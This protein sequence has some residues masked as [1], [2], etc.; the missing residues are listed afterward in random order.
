[1]FR[2][3]DGDK[4]W[5]ALLALLFVLLIALLGIVLGA[6]N[7]ASINTIMTILQQP[8]ARTATELTAN[9]TQRVDGAHHWTGVQ[10]DRQLFFSPA[11]TWSP[12]QNDSLLCLQSGLFYVYASMQ[13]HVLPP[14]S[15]HTLPL[16]CG[17]CRLRG[18]LRA[19][20]Q[21]G[22]SGPQ[23]EVPP[24]LTQQSRDVSFMSKSFLL[25]AQV[26][27][28]LRVQFRSP[29]RY[30]ALYSGHSVNSSSYNAYPTSATLVVS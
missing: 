15:N 29:C 6:Q 25:Q 20:L 28:V 5:R 10:Y 19:T 21:L 26:G 4:A 12:A 17:A 14:P 18:A 30:L 2:V 11:W 9:T 22:G 1:M 7:L 27:D 3:R 8:P 23:L 24:S 13:T 16:D